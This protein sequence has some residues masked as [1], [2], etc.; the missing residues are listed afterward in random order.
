MQMDPEVSKWMG[1]GADSSLLCSGSGFRYCLFSK[2]SCIEGKGLRFAVYKKVF[3][4]DKSLI[5]LS[6]NW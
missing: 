4:H 2:T 5:A 1:T 3:L 6:F